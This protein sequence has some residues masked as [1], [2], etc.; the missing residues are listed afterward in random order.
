MRCESVREDLNTLSD[1]ERLADWRRYLAVGKHSLGCARCRAEWRR[2]KQLRQ[3]S[4][5]LPAPPPPADIRARVMTALPEAAAAPVGFR[6]KG[7]GMVL[8]LL[9]GVAV[10]AALTLGLLTLPRSHRSSTS[11]AAEVQQALQ[12]VNTWHLQGWKLQSGKKVSWEVWGR[13]T[14]FFYREQVGTELV[15]DDGQKRTALLGKDPW[16]PRPFVLRTPSNP[17]AKN[18]RWSYRKMVEKWQ[19][20][21]K[22][23]KETPEAVI[24]NLPDSAVPVG[25]KTGWKFPQNAITEAL[26]TIDRRTRLPMQYEAYRDKAKVAHLQVAF[27]VALPKS[28]LAPPPTP[29]SFRV[30]DTTVPAVGLPRA[31]TV[32]QEGVTLQLVPLVMDA[33]GHVLLRL[34]GW[35]GSTPMDG[36]GPFYLHADIR[37]REAPD[38]MSEP[39]PTHDDRNRSYLRVYWNVLQR[40]SMTSPGYELMLLAPVEPLPKGK[41]LPKRLTVRGTAYPQLGIRHND[42]LGMEDSRLFER[43]FT[44]AVSLPRRVKPMNVDAYLKPGWR[45]RI[46]PADGWESREAATDF[47]RAHYYSQVIDYRHLDRPRLTRAIEWKQKAIAASTSDMARLER[48]R[49]V[50]L[51]GLLGRF[52]EARQTLQEMMTA[53]SKSPQ[54]AAYDRKMAKW[55][56]EWLERRERAV[57]P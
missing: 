27:E 29:P 35:L 40:G 45:K 21:L 9:G 38:A 48:D 16:Q 6:R 41:P 25:A 23:W 53:R 22:P 43:E 54:L 46:V 49:L 11:F 2:L 12:Q 51:Y 31:N 56:L 15:M 13:R 5:Y 47:A 8:K 57:H 52:K 18:I 10:T 24:F 34:K 1:G 28:I 32:S 7:G 19:A 44:L 30:Y 33:D 37:I 50:E 39:S 3:L 26:F 14:P 36:K 42:M 17:Q 55:R 20:D 4:R